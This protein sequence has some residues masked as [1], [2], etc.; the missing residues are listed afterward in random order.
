[1]SSRPRMTVG[2]MAMP[3]DASSVRI[4]FGPVMAVLAPLSGTGGSL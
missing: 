3:M 1:M 2:L 4:R